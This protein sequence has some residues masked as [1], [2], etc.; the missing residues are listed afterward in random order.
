MSRDSLHLPHPLPTRAPSR[1]ELQRQA[2][3]LGEQRDIGQ[4]HQVDYGKSFFLE[5]TTENSFFL[6]LFFFEGVHL[7]PAIPGSTLLAVGALEILFYSKER[8]GKYCHGGF[9]TLPYKISAP[10]YR[11]C[12]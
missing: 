8:R 6:N 12:Q 7:S 5:K 3:S 11:R 9:S 1:R 10:L 4:C 2:L